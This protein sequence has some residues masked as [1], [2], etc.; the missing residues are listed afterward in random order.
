[1]LLKK[2]SLH[3]HFFR[4]FL[5]N[6]AIYQAISIIEFK[7]T[8]SSSG[9]SQG[10]YICDIQD[11][12]SNLWYR[13]NDNNHPVQIRQDQVTTNAY[14]VLLKKSDVWIYKLI[15]IYICYLFNSI[16]WIRNISL[17]NK[18]KR[19]LVLIHVLSKLAQVLNSVTNQF[20]LLLQFLLPEVK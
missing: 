5:G 11:Q 12:S 14:V 7:G 16:K 18:I 15:V 20:A 6:I 1:M 17:F 19:S 2:I 4:D 10:H 8:I 3:F 13:T 9:R